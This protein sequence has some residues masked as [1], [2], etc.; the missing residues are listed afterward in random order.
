MSS[1]S[2]LGFT[3]PSDGTLTLVFNSSCS[4]YTIYIN[5]GNSTAIPS[6]GIIV[7]EV[8]AGTSYTITK[9][10]SESFLYYVVFT[11]NA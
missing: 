1:S 6:D 4:G 3:A 2:S 10:K 7:I 9:N 11:P 5:G 8:T